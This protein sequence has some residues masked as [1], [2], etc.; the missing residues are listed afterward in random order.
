MNHSLPAWHLGCYLSRSRMAT[1]YPKAALTT[2]AL[3]AAVGLLLSGCGSQGP[4]A[5]S[6][7]VSQ[8]AA[9]DV[10]DMTVEFGEPVQGR[11]RVDRPVGAG[12]PCGARSGGGE[13][14]LGAGRSSACASPRSG[15][16]DRLAVFHAGIF[17]E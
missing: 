7:D 12:L 11:G 13:L 15:V 8:A 16:C 4:E 2:S 10:Q 14:N 5:E 3:V 17:L 6:I 9:P 1:R